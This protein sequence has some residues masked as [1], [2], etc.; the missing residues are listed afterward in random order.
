[1]FASRLKFQGLLSCL[2]LAALLTAC[3]GGSSSSSS[4]STDD[5]SGGSTTSQGDNTGSVNVML[6]DAPADLDLFSAINASIERIELI[7][8]D[9]NRFPLFEGPTETID[10]LSLRNEAM[11]FAYR[12]DVP[13]GSYCK[14]RLTLSQP[15]GLEL[16]L[17][18]DGSS[19]YPNLPG[20]GK[21]DLL[22]RGC[23]TVSEGAPI[24]VQID[25]D[26]G[27]SIHVVQTGNR[28]RYN[29]RPVVLIDVVDAEFSAKLVRMEGVIRDSD[30]TTQ[31]LLLCDTL[32]NA[33]AE[34]ADCITLQLGP[35]S[36]YFDN[37]S[38][39]GDA[40][41]LNAVLQPELRGTAATAVGLTSS[42]PVQLTPVEVP[43][44]AWPGTGFCRLWEAGVDPSAQSSTDDQICNDPDL[45][46]PSGWVLVDDQG[47]VVVDHRPRLTLDT[48]VV[49]T[50]S[51]GDFAGSVT[52]DASASQFTLQGT[53][54]LLVHLQNPQ[55]YNGT[56]I[57]SNLGEVLD[58]TAITAPLS[59]TLDGVTE[60]DSVV[61]A[62]LVIIDP[63]QLDL[64]AASGE[65][66]SLNGEGFILIPEAGTSPCDV[67]GDVTVNTTA[68]T[69]YTTV[70]TTA[71][72]VEVSPGGTLE[73][74][75]SVNVNG[76]C[77]SGVLT[78]TSVV[79]QIDETL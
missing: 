17:A 26:A 23:F 54:P 63:D 39:A 43:E 29:F 7:G 66:A 56:R 64:I 22:A 44:E 74:G 37:L 50:G 6:T 14:I 12:D 79:I 35:Q 55:G 3:G 32:P 78:A 33:Q 69:D 46:V 2:V 52:V 40:Q 24:T 36:A 31:S 15:D 8:G 34:A 5:S 20:N 61:K 60:S 11:P 72:Q 49:E 25:L 68:E 62:A 1:M 9:E 75:Q 30:A 77:D 59:L 71:D 48:L 13:A 4:T 27:N 10:L 65:V 41:P 42:Q 67:S 47:L 73:A 51:F 45:H 28:T 70:T 18:V 16:V 58:Y 57:L 53:A 38:E 21:I 19:E 76:S